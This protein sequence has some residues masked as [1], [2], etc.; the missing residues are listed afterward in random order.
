MRSEKNE[1]K[2]RN[3]RKSWKRRAMGMVE[4]G[5]GKMEKRGV[6]RKS[7]HADVLIRHSGV[8]HISFAWRGVRVDLGLGVASTLL[9]HRSFFHPAY[10]LMRHRRE[11]IFSPTFCAE[12][13]WRLSTRAL[14]SWGGGDRG[15][16]EN[17]YPEVVR[18]DSILR[19]NPGPMWRLAARGGSKLLLSSPPFISLVETFL[20]AAFLF[21]FSDPPRPVHPSPSGPT[22]HPFVLLLCFVGVVGKFCT[23]FPVPLATRAMGLF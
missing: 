21:P 19:E 6:R 3:T 18:H 14:Y 16:S 23:T 7:A 2:R 10:F 5:S 9:P 11:F 4:E 15:G 1:E 12:K 20:F 13:N 8:Q 22:F 17:S